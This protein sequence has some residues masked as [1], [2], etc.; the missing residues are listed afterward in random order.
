MQIASLR[1]RANTITPGQPSRRERQARGDEASFDRRLQTLWP[2]PRHH[3][4][5]ELE[6]QG[7]SLHRVRQRE[8]NSGRSRGDEWVR[9]VRK[10][11]ERG[12][13]PDSQRRHR[14]TQGTCHVRGAQAQEAHAKR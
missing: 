4:Q 9:D 12:Q 10:G 7:T 6:A 14:Y 8:I 3:N 13:G 11:L 2:Y 1:M 5:D